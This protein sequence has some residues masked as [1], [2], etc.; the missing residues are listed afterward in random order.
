[1]AA[2]DKPLVWLRGEV[3]TPPFSFDARIEAGVSATA[4][5]RGT[6]VAAAFTTHAEHWNSLP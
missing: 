1:M 4:T 2:E 3:K 6:T 5:A